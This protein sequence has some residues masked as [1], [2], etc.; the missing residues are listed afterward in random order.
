MGNLQTKFFCQN[1]GDTNEWA[2][3]LLGERWQ[4]VNSTNVGQSRQESGQ[5]ID[6]GNL[7]SGVTR[8]DQRRYFVEPSTFT[9]LK[10]GGELHGFHVQAIVYKGGHLFDSGGKN[11]LP[12]KLLTFDQR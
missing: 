11:L 2:A 6:R 12:Y 1:S 9:T 10:R 8:S 3:K 5:I 7:S 4:A